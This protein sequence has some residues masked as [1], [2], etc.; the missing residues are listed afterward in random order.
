MSCLS[1][2]LLSFFFG[3]SLPLFLKKIYT[4]KKIA[5]YNEKYLR[6]ESDIDNRLRDKYYASM[7]DAKDKTPQLTQKIRGK[8][9]DLDNAMNRLVWGGKAQLPAA[10]GGGGNNNSNTNLAGNDDDDGDD[11]DESTKSKQKRKKQAKKKRKGKKK[12]DEKSKS[13][14]VEV[15]QK[16]KDQKQ[17]NKLLVVQSLAAGITI[18]AA[19]VFAAVVVDSSRKSK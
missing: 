12:D 9:L 4:K 19:A 6:N 18:G 7:V 3:T 8:D 5:A 16:E 14:A 15:E 2:S 11:D 1:V 13:L 17:E 10:P